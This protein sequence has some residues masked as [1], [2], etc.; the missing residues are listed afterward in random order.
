MIKILLVT[1][2][3]WSDHALIPFEILSPISH[4]PSCTAKKMSRPWHKVNNLLLADA[5]QSVSAQSRGL[6]QDA[7]LFNDWVRRLKTLLLLREYTLL[8]DSRL[9]PLGSPTLKLL[10]SS[11]KR[12]G[13]SWRT[14]YDAEAKATYPEAL[15]KYKAI[16]IYSPESFY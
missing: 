2:L 15:K 6:K 5:L 7:V 12:L 9:Q 14:N 10:K 8:R 13:R 16:N 3:T 11:Y 4:I 1:N